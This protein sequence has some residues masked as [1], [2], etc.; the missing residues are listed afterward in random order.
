MPDSLRWVP[1]CQLGGAHHGWG[2]QGDGGCD[3][4]RKYEQLE[5]EFTSR[6][7]YVGTGAV[8]QQVRDWLFHKDLRH[9]K[10]V[11]PK[12]EETRFSIVSALT[13]AW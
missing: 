10:A 6:S 12:I 8:I 7:V 3:S 1:G 4:T 5:F 9:T 11:F 2:I 13:A